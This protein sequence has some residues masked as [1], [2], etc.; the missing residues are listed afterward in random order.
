MMSFFPRSIRENERGAMAI[1]LALFAPIFATVVI[2]IVDLSNGFSRK[3]AIE[4]GAHRAI[5]KIMQTTGVAT[6]QNTLEAEAIC[7]VN[8]V[9]DDGSCR[10]SPITAANVTVTY[11]LECTNAGTVNSSL[12]RTNADDFDALTCSSSEQEARYIEVNITDTYQ[13]MFKTYFGSSP[14][15]KYHISA[16]AGMRTQ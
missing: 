16:T 12:T 13:P 4:Q 3:L 1:E 15:G 9:N 2:G 14:D 5:E 11:R 10:D 7:Q 6:V 8:G